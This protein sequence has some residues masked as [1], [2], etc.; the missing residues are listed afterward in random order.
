[1]KKLL[2]PIITLAVAATTAW[3]ASIWKI[4]VT[5]VP[6]DTATRCDTAIVTNGMSRSHIIV[7][8]NGTSNAAYVGFSNAVS[9]SANGILLVANGGALTIDR[10]DIDEQIWVYSTSGTDIA[11]LEGWE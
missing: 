2:L 3:A 5:T 10:T 8:N 11:V 7:V 4:T 1:M 6:A 9:A